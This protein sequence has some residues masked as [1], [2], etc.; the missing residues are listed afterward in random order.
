MSGDK[1]MVDYSLLT[2][3]MHQ[4]H[5]AVLDD[6]IDFIAYPPRRLVTVTSP[7]A[8]LR[9]LIS[10]WGSNRNIPVVFS[11]ECDASEIAEYEGKYLRQ[12]FD[13]VGEDTCIVVRLDTFPARQG[14]SD[15]LIN[16]MDRMTKEGAKF[17]TGSTK[18]YRSDEPT[19]NPNYLKT[20]RISN[21]FLI[22]EA[23][24]WR[25]L[26]ARG[27]GFRG[28]FGRYYAEGI[29]EKLCAIDNIFGMRIANTNHWR[30]LHTQAWGSTAPQVREAV[31]N[32][33]DAIL[34]FLDGYQDDLF[35][36]PL[37]EQYFMYPKP[38]RMKLLRITLGRWRRNL[39]NLLLSD[40]GRPD[41]RNE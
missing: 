15:W 8:S 13:L 28:E 11:G 1:W 22:V 35:G 16:S 29:I 30:V 3:I 5:L 18:R 21:N 23:P 36:R 39:I 37:W 41:S 26:Y 12:Q 10:A 38:S 19:D 34:P 9:D 32:G 24:V 27:E 2:I 4:D 31:K 25:A 40:R 14:H 6:W 33:G 17:I 7:S 20:R